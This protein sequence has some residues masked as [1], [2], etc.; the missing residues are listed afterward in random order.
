MLI[1]KRTYKENYTKGELKIKDYANFDF[2]ELT[3][4]NNKKDISC[5]P[6]DEY[7]V[8]CHNS[9]KF[10]K[11]LKVF[12]AGKKEVIGRTDIL[13][14]SGNA[15]AD[16]T[17]YNSLKQMT[18]YKCDSKGCLLVGFGFFEVKD[19]E[20]KEQ[21]YITGSRK[22]LN[23]LYNYIEMQGGIVELLITSQKEEQ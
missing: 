11:C 8:K 19:I 18:K 21:A 9:P 23:F 6:E 20:D 16:F 2:L 22:A 1:L 14:H 13:I 10:G 7:L 5:I 4:N 17:F 12:N 15:V 3:Y